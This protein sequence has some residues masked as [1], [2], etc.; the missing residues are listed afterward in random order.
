MS[1]TVLAT[2]YGNFDFG[3]LSMSMSLSQTM[4]HVSHV[5]HVTLL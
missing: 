1:L 4:T 2:Y 3:L 5:T